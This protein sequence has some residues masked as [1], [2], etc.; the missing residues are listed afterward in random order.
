MHRFIADILD[1]SSIVEAVVLVIYYMQ[2]R[3][4]LEANFQSG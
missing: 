3:M 2:L 1:T 4:L